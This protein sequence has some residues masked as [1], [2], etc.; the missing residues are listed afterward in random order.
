MLLTACFRLY[1]I[2]A[3]SFSSCEH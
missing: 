2:I 3:N 1:L